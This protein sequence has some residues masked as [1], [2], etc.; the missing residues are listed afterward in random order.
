[1]PSTETGSR[2]EL[3]KQRTRQSIKAAVLDL[4]CGCPIAA[5]T[6]EQIADQAGVSRRT[7]F[8]YYAGIDAVLAEATQEPMLAVFESFLARPAS[9]DP[10]T[11]MINALQGPIP[12][13]LARWCAALCRPGN[14][15]SEVHA[16]VWQRHTDWLA[17]VLRARLGDDADPMYVA[18]LA[19]SV[20]SL[21]TAAQD[22]WMTSTQGRLDAASLLLFSELLRTALG[23]ARD[24]WRTPQPTH[25]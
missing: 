4:A 24:G 12:W 16:Q 20:M 9:E 21:F 23:H 13:D 5:I 7:F 22:R 1:M 18:S 3:N 10:L 19:G 2:R 11:A 14:Q 17:R 25:H 8:N 15:E 6:A